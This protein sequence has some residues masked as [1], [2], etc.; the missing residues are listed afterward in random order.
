MRQYLRTKKRSGECC[1]F[2]GR[3]EGEGAGGG[4]TRPLNINIQK[5]KRDERR[6]DEGKLAVRSE[7]WGRISLGRSSEKESGTLKNLR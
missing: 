7:I 3:R 6:R 5:K 4:V 2:I 1:F